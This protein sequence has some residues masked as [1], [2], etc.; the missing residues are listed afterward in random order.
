MDNPNEEPKNDDELIESTQNLLELLLGPGVRVAPPQG[1]ESNRDALPLHSPAQIIANGIVSTAS[2]YHSVL[3]Q[4][5]TEA[6]SAAAAGAAS[7]ANQ[8]LRNPEAVIGAAGVAAMAARGAVGG[9]RGAAD[10]Q[11]DAIN[12]PAVELITG[13]GAAQRLIGALG[14]GVNGVVGVLRR[15]PGSAETPPPER[16]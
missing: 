7:F 5:A 2:L 13:A 4:S 11:P 16:R 14:E 10:T 12:N 8:A 15:T 3:T 6:G 1:N 9:A